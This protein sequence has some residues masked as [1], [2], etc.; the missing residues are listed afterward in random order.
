[1]PGLILIV[2]RSFSKYRRDFFEILAARWRSGQ[3]RFK[4]N[5]KVN[6]QP[7]GAPE[8]KKS[9][10]H[11]VAS[12]HPSIMQKNWEDIPTVSSDTRLLVSD[13]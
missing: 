5:K 10:R 12:K 1:M 8:S 6:F 13:Q 3:N 7:V 9:R 2:E 11:V 4:N